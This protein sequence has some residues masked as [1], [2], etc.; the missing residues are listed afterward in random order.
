MAKDYDL[1]G[2]RQNRVPFPE[3]PFYKFV[4]LFF[5][6]IICFGSYFAYDAVANFENNLEED[7]DTNDAGYGLLYSI[8]SFPNFV[9][10]FFGGLLGDKIGLRAAGLV[11]VVLVVCGAVIVALGPTLAGSGA[12]AGKAGFIVTII[13]RAVFGAGAESLSVIQTSMVSLWF[14]KGGALAFSMSL[15][16]SVARLGD[17]LSLA[18]SNYIATGFGSYHAVLWIGAILCGVSFVSVII[19]SILDKAAERALPDRK[20]VSSENPLQ[21]KAVLKFDVRFWIIALLCMAYYSGV[22]PFV[23]ICTK[24]LKTVHN[25]PTENAGWYASVV[26]LSS[27]ALSPVLGKLLDRVGRRP[28]FVVLGSILIIPMHVVLALLPVGGNPY[29][30]LIPIIVI[31]LSFSIVPSA[32]WPCIPLIIKDEETATAFGLMAAI[33][34]FGLFMMNLL[35]GVIADSDPTY[36]WPMLFFVLMDTIGLVCGIIL[37]IVDKSKGSTLSGV[38][39]GAQSV[40]ETKP[41]VSPTDSR[42]N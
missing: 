10:P 12:I 29:I 42:L 6:S 1:V 39:G 36:K 18:I 3:R 20:P 22:F 17:F 24:Y 8:Y 5:I 33:Q 7:L 35:V 4:V 25:V 26:T 38:H 23:A 41:L 30:P 2:E 21:F 28:Y 19:Y 9:L 31:G 32:L 14:S 15:T 37:I 11:Y 16:L 34:N 13:G 40:D 27:M